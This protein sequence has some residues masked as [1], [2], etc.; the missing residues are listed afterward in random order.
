MKTSSGRLLAVFVVILVAPPA[1]VR[2]AGYEVGPGKPYSSIGAVPWATL[3]PGDTVR[4]FWRAEPYREKWVIGRSGT[5]ASPILVTGVKG[6][7]GERPVIDGDGAVTAPGLNYWSETRGVIKIGGSNVPPDGVPAHVVLEG[8]EIRNARTVHTFTGDDGAA[9][10]YDANAATIY[11]E[12]G[13]N[14]TIRDCVMHGAGN[15]LFVASGDEE[16]SRDI[17]IEGNWIYDNG[18]PG[19]IYEH[20]SYTAAAGITF[21]YNRYGPLCSGCGGNNL[22][23]R[24]SGTVIRYNWIEGGNRQLDLVDA[25][26]SAAIRSDPAYAATFVYGNVLIEPAGA[27]NRQI[28]HYGGDSGSTAWYRKGSLYFFSNTVVS[29]RTDRTTLFRLSTNDEFADARDNIVFLSEAGGNTL[30]LMDSAGRL[31]WSH[32][33]AE[34]GY[35]VSFGSFSGAVNDDGT[36]VTGT[37]P[38]FLDQGGEDYHLT[39]DS[40]CRDA[41]RPLAPAVLPDHA[42]VREYRKHQA[43]DPRLQDGD[44]DIGAYEFNA[45]QP[46]LPPEGVSGFSVGPGSTTLSWSAAARAATYDVVA[47]DLSILRASGGDFG[48]AT[49]ECVA[50]D[51][52]LLQAEDEV[53]PAAGSGRWLLARAADCTGRNGPYDEPAGGQT[54]TRDPGL[55]ASPHACP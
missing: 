1:A 23:D 34:P 17:L 39:A 47:G 6:P 31:D 24:S 20:N 45:C 37:A 2:A 18:N 29:R 41:G 14:I 4:I 22:K 21:Q 30:S 11:L 43:G 9:H 13:R 52:F 8:L 5:V 54:G 35:A 26:D 50:D 42:V 25:E 51:T 3:Q 33:W 53:S 16:P 15:G 38:G 19:S 46:G 49:E 28:L 36:T 48:Q 27:G 7:N 44:I 32:N 10:T 12:K 55:A 40:S